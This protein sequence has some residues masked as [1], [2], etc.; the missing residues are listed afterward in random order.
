MVAEESDEEEVV[1][2]EG[3]HD[4]GVGEADVR[5]GGVV[6]AQG[7]EHEHAVGEVGALH[8]GQSVERKALEVILSAHPVALPRPGST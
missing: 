4:V 7:F 8:L 3:A 2:D 6:D 5:H 1:V